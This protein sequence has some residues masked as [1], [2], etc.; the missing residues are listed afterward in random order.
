MTFDEFST[1]QIPS[2]LKDLASASPSDWPTLRVE[3]G[4][5]DS[6]D[7]SALDYILDEKGTYDVSFLRS[8]IRDH[9][10]L[11]VYRGTASENEIWPGA[12]VTLA[13]DYARMHSRRNQGSLDSP[14]HLLSSQV[15]WD[16]LSVS[17]QHELLFVPRDLHAWHH[18]QVALA[19][20]RG[21]N[22]PLSVLAEFDLTSP[23]AA[24]LAL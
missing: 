2:P 15:Q 9:S 14:P 8:A 16:E 24:P 5:L 3:L 1:Y 12:W 23:T 20:E 11:T 6:F 10:P 19:I 18:A 17:G 7:D 21:E 4:T 22:V 13:S